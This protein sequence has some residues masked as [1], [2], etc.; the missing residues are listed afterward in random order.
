MM[1]LTTK[2][3]VETYGTIEQRESYERTG[4][5]ATRTKNSIMKSIEKD[6]IVEIQKEG[7]NSFYIVTKREVPR[8][9]NYEDCMEVILCTM[10]DREPN[11]Q[12][13]VTTSYIM[14]NFGVVNDKY[15]KVKRLSKDNKD[16]YCKINELSLENFHLICNDT[17]L[18]DKV[19]YTLKKLEDRRLCR[20]DRTYRVSYC[21]ESVGE[22]GDITNRVAKTYTPSETL[23]NKILE[24][25]YLYL[26][27]LDEKA[28]MAS[29]IKQGKMIQ[30]QNT[31]NL[32]LKDSILQEL[33]KNI[34]L[35]ENEEIKFNFYYKAKVITST[36]TIMKVEKAKTYYQKSIQTLNELSV[37]TMQ[38]KVNDRK[39][40]LNGKITTIEQL[41]KFKLDGN[42]LIDLL[43]KI[44]D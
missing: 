43:V 12:I 11:N 44:S 41:D 13:V 40:D 30:F 16:G 27:S 36:E 1:K 2:E 34:K 23:I 37:Q 20:I 29:L 9:D 5:L 25:E 33:Y 15:Y 18:R 10:L 21:I 3:F 39:C 7:R 31:M 38:K 14:E 22:D 26:S 42:K 8:L 28:S 24:E 4:K 6:Y 19:D 32:R 17:T 35:K